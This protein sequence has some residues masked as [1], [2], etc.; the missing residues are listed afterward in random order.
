MKREDN[1]MKKVL[2]VVLCVVLLTGL[3]AGCGNSAYNNAT[4]MLEESGSSYYEI[5]SDDSYIKIDTNPADMDDFYDP[6]STQL[7]QDVNTELGFPESLY[8][9]M[10]STSALD[11]I[12]TDENDYFTVRWSYHPDHGLEIMY[13]EK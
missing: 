2:I 4:K 1:W 10:T 13:E 5:A 11:G 3:L 12:Q 8:E 6:E 9:K 7:I